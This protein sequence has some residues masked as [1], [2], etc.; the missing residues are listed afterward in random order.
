M[1]NNE[2]DAASVVK[3]I[4]EAIKL[5]EDMMTA[6]AKIGH[7]YHVLGEETY[8]EFVKALYEQFPGVERPGPKQDIINAVALLNDAIQEHESIANN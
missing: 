7:T 6:C 8:K 5:P 4:L 3:M 1:D 2:K